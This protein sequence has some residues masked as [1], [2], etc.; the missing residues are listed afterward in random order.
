V[1]VD[2]LTRLT[3]D[4]VLD[5]IFSLAPSSRLA[6]LGMNRTKLNNW[7]KLAYQLKVITWDYDPEGIVKHMD[8]FYTQPL[9]GKSYISI[10]SCPENIVLPFREDILLIVAGIVKAR[11]M[12]EWFEDYIRKWEDFVEKGKCNFHVVGGTHRTLI[13]PPHLGNF[14]KVLKRVLEERGL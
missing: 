13:S 12:K 3:N 11:S 2:F 4:E 14:W 7:A 9:I 6:E 10:F 8:V 5:H 1:C